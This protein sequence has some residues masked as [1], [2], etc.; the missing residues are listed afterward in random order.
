MNIFN[1]IPYDVTQYV[2][3]PYLTSEDRG[4]FNA[5]LEPTERVYRPFPKDFAIKHCLKTFASVQKEHVARISAAMD[6]CY[7]LIENGIGPDSNPNPLAPLSRYI[8]FIISPQAKLMFQHKSKAKQSALND[9][10]LF[11]DEQEC[12]FDRF[13]DMKMYR[14]ILH[15]IDI[16]QNTPFIREV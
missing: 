12:P 6:E 8:N 13:M 11:L 4:N 15:A 9:L 10:N 1:F 5:V 2:L 14:T 7:E 3:N 16:V